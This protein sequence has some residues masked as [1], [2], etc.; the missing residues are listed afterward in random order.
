[1]AGTHFGV[2]STWTSF[3]LCLHCT[4]VPGG[5]FKDNLTLI[6]QIS[7]YENSE[8]FEEFLFLDFVCPGQPVTCMGPELAGVVGDMECMKIITA[9]IICFCPLEIEIPFL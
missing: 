7:L 4:L 9:S 5:S 8:A 6:S 2:S 1:M 3:I